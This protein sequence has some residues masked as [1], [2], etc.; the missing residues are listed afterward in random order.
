MLIM[1]MIRTTLRLKPELKKEAEMLA[2]KGNMTFQELFNDALYDFLR[3][4]KRINKIVFYDK[5][6]SKKMNNLTR[7]E[8]YE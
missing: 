1:K 3:G 2:L 6:I 7:D 4:K 5:P 8:I